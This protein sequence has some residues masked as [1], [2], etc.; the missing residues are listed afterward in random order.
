MRFHDIVSDYYHA[1][2]SQEERSRKQEEWLT[3]KTRV[4]VCTNAFGM[5]I[6]KPDVRTVIHV[7]TPDCL[8]NYYQEAG[9][10]GRDGQKSYAVLLYNEKDLVELEEM[11]AVRFPVL[12][13]I[14]KV[15]Q[16][17]ANYLQLPAGME[18]GEYYDFDFADM[19]ARFKLD[20][21]TTLYALKA[22]EQDGWIAMNEQVFKPGTVCFTTSRTKLNEFENSHPK[23]DP[24]IK[25]MLRTYEGIFDQ[26]TFIS[27]LL[28]AQLLKKDIAAIKEQLVQLH[29]AG[30]IEY[31]PRKE[32]PQL[33]LLRTRVR[34]EELGI[35]MT[36]YE[37][38]KSQFHQRAKV[39][40][41]YVREQQKCRSQVIGSY[42]GDSDLERC[43]VCDN[44]LREKSTRISEEDFEKIA[45]QV[46]RILNNRRVPVKELIAELKQVKKEKAWKVIEFLQ[47]EKRIEVDSLGWVSMIRR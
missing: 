42:F 22:L 16:A 35:D 29:R 19:I 41:R 20:P 39:M 32:S 6:D 37:L 1:G 28:L 5:G 25:S 45:M 34:S 26:P 8:E 14:R 17:T 21:P 3:D 47:S 44:C 43:G 23:L 38:R 9:R 40:I 33:R 31:L 36:Q 2:L 12:E 30:I 7:D 11:I 18:P 27:E 15:Y 13:E 4:I 10:A 46:D 24:L